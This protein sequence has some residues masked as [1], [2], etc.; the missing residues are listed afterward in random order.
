[1]PRS[2]V[3]VLALL[4]AM[5]FTA[6]AHAD[7]G[8]VAGVDAGPTGV[9]APGADSRYVTLPTREGTLVARIRRDGG[10]IERWRVLR[11]TLAV[12]A[13]AYDGTAT[14]LSADGRTLAL[15]SPRAGYPRRRSRFVV[16]DAHRLAPRLAFRLRG[17]FT[18][19]AVSPDGRR[20]F[21]IEQTSRRDL[22]R[23]AV[24]AYDVGA[25]RLDPRPVV[26]PS[27]PD[28][29]MRGSPLA[30]VASADGRWAYTLYDGNGTHPF[31]HA[32]DT[33]A[34]SAKCVDL[35]ALAGRK[36]LPGLRLTTARDGSLVVR[37]PSRQRALLVVDPRSFAV[38]EPAAARPAAPRP[39]PRDDG[40]GVPWA[41]VLGA[42][43]LLTLLAGAALA[44][45]LRTTS[46]LSARERMG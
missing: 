1:M 2:L 20:L 12:P 13:V 23:Y 3:A 27:E 24:R 44:A 8:P 15:A 25:R 38:R 40:G 36:D 6:P 34:A 16:L 26:D 43:A 32:L 22:T 35:D 19:D 14:G 5:S 45:R 39:A 37:E 41:L 10:Q 21:L 46:S 9:T 7:G 28:E 30:R 17:D 31:I 29:P 18:L 11:R 33:A 4:A 42:G